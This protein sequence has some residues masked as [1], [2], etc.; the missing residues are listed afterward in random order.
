MSL[1]GFRPTIFKSI[2]ITGGNTGLLTTGVSY[3]NPA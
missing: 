1:I 3:G 2:G